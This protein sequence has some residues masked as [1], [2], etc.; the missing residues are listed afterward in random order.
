MTGLIVRWIREAL[1]ILEADSTP[2]AWLTRVASPTHAV[3][4]IR[5]VSPTR[6]VDTIPVALTTPAVVTILALPPRLR[7]ELRV[8]AQP[9]LGAPVWADRRAS[10]AARPERPAWAEALPEWGVPAPA[11][12]RV[13]VVAP[14]V[15]LELEGVPQALAAQA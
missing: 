10:A 9:G 13:S 2:V 7:T 1:G 6:V 11:D 15:R 14:L 5:V 3:D 8:P 4:T 12:R